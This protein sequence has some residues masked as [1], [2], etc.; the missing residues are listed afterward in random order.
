[1][2]VGG[3]RR[4]ARGGTGGDAPPPHGGL[5]RLGRL[6]AGGARPGGRVARPARRGSGRGSSGPGLRR[7]ETRYQLGPVLRV[8]AVGGVEGDPVDDA[9]VAV[10]DEAGDLADRT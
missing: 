9:A 10:E 3:P 2:A 4:R 6:L 1:M 7:L 8:A 5:R